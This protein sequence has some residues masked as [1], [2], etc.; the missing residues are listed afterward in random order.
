MQQMLFVLTLFAGLAVVGC[1]PPC[2]DGIAGVSCNPSCGEGEAH[3]SCSFSGDC[4]RDMVCYHNPEND[5]GEEQ[6]CS[7]GCAVIYSEGCETHDDCDS[8]AGQFCSSNQC[9]GYYEE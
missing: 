1:S 5:V 3:S 9:L 2:S 6:P 8:A 7:G 4:L